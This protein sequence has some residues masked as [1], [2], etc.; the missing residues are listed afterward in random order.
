MDS[1]KG[2]KVLAERFGGCTPSSPIVERS[3][4]G[5]TTPGLPIWEWVTPSAA[6]GGDA[7]SGD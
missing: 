6:P 7:L 4:E 2:A 1:L 3:P 5:V